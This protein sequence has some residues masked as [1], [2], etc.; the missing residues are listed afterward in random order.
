MTGSLT[1]GSAVRGRAAEDGVPAIGDRAVDIVGVVAFVA[2]VGATVVVLLLVRRWLLARSQ[3]A[4]ECHVRTG[5]TGGSWRAGVARYEAARLA[6]FATLSLAWW[7][8]LV[9]YRDRLSVVDRRSAADDPAGPTSASATTIILRCRYG[10]RVVEIAMD[11]RVA[12]GFAVWVESGPPGR[13]IN[14]A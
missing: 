14:V 2:V 12:G 8:S 11:D 5:G 3:G 7:P 10:G 13:G 9:L 4:F 6:V 1:S